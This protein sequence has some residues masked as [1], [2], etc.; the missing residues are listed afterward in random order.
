MHEN[1]STEEIRVLLEGARTVAVVGLSDRPH[2][3]SHSIA[4]ALQDFGFRIFP[5]NPNL[6]GPVLGEEPFATVEEIGAPVDI[7]D[8]FRRSEKVMQTARD[9]VAAGAK[10]LWMQS[11][12]INEEAASF[13]KEHGLRVVMDRCI[14]VEYATLVRG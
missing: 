3:T 5:V 2:R 12:V 14:M 1:P 10:V 11:G 6:K 7:V 4:R 9:A 8:V 13:A